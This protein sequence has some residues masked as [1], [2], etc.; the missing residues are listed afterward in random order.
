MG[1]EEGLP[2][3]EKKPSN[4]DLVV[5]VVRESPEPLPFAE[6]LERVN[7]L[8]PITT[9]DPK[10]TIRNAVSQSRLVVATGD[11]RYG[12]KYRLINGA[13]IRLPLSEADLAQHWV[14]Y[15]D[16]VR[17][18]LWP[19]FFE[20]QKR[21]DREPVALELPDSRSL[22]WTLG[23]RGN[24]VWGTG[25]SPEFWDWLKDGGARPGD[26]LIFRVMDGEARRYA[27]GFQPR[28]ERDE[29]AIAARNQQILQAVDR[30]NQHSR[31]AL[32]I[33]DVSSHLLCTGQYHDPIPPDPLEA[34][35]KDKLWG[36]DLPQILGIPGWMLAK[37]PV[38]DPLVASL[39][40]QIGKPSRRHRLKEEAAQPLASDRIYQLK[41]TL[42]G[43]HPPIWRR[44]QA[45]GRLTL[46]QLHA[47]LQI[48]LGWT[49]SHLHGFRVREQFYTEPSPDYLDLEVMDERQVRLNQIAPE[50]G[51]R[52]I[53]E[54][55][56]GDSWDH[57]LVVEQILPP[58][59]GVAYPRC[60]AGK[61]A[62][63]PEDVGGA[64]GYTEFLAA[65]Q[66]PRHPEHVEWLQWVG[67]RFDPDVLDLQAVNE[68]LQSF[69]T[70]LMGR[71]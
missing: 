24:G 6:I 47:V 51:D 59:L 63:P 29:P 44:I 4:A 28:S 46:P 69:Y 31:G 66:N 34:L 55:D 19:A 62:C 25:G 60:T 27:V 23:S 8:A 10:S 7:A 26:E 17:D 70:T 37:Q 21:S 36:L 67:G 35:L 38:I 54:Y 32:A 11:G 42:E 43:V 18:A 12:W 57:A 1:K 50:V 53:Y 61:R 39:L 15:S 52:F 49:N 16:E 65:I 5:Q 13:V 64:P 9:R 33:W 22:V 45:P 14:T 68:L 3:P 58:D 2:M 30:Y 48:A 56:F 20:S 41:V 71:E 40:D